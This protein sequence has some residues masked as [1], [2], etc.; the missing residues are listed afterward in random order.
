MPLLLEAIEAAVVEA[1]ETA[2]LLPVWP[3]PVWPLLW[4][5]PWRQVMVFLSE[6]GVVDR[7]PAEA[8]EAALCELYSLNTSFLWSPEI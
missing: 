8:E 7:P 5:D 3:F 2:E 4:L 1:A 6:E